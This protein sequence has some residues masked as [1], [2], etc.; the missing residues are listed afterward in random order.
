MLSIPFFDNCEKSDEFLGLFCITAVAVST[1]MIHCST[2]SPLSAA[3]Y[4]TCL[5]Q[6][7]SVY[8]A[9]SQALKLS[10]SGLLRSAWFPS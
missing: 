2:V 9:C 4:G 5:E 8:P 3:A 6:N 10:S 1:F 7:D